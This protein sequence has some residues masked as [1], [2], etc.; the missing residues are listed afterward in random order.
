MKNLLTR[1]AGVRVGHADDQ[2]GS[3]VTAVIFDTPAVAAID[4][5]GGGPGTP[6][7]A[8]RPRQYGGASDAIP[9]G[10]LGVRVEA[11]AGYRPG[12]P[13]GPRFP[14][15]QPS[16]RSSR[17]IMFDLRN[18]RQQA[19][20][21]FAPYAILACTAGRSQRRIRARQRRPG[22]GRPPRI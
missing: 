4:V 15:P 10:W 1:I 19:W 12:S 20:G 5:R 18:G 17:A 21:R 7:R 2:A 6:R 22:L 8:A 9:L 13:T 11:A 14:H 3:G 16:F